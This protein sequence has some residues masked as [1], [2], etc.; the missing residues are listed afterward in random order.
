MV[1]SWARLGGRVGAARRR[2][3]SMAQLGG[4]AAAADG[5]TWRLHDGAVTSVTFVI[6]V[7]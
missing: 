4:S 6:A 1:A 5:R 7:W 2:D 3:G